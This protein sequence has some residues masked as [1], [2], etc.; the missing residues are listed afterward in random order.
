M[1]CT[2]RASASSCSKRS[3][4]HT[5]SFHGH[6]SAGLANLRLERDKW[7]W[8]STGK[9]RSAIVEA[10]NEALDAIESRLG[11]HMSRWSRGALHKVD[12]RH[13]LSG[14]GD[15]RQ[16]LNRGGVPVRGNGVTVCNTGFDPN[17]GADLGANY[18]LIAD[19]HTSPPALMA[20]DAQGT[21]GH[22]AATTTA[23]SWPN[24]SRASITGSV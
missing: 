9:P 11:P 4:F 5:D 23:I 17:W 6:T 2:T 24:G 14:R 20:I 21:S 19:L 8:F 18:R 22:R 10:F 16:L 13:V 15:L 7:G 1:A 12:R 3:L